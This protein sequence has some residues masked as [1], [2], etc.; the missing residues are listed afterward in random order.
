MKSVVR[1][2][3]NAPALLSR[4]KSLES[5]FSH[6]LKELAMAGNFFVFVARA[7]FFFSEARSAEGT[8]QQGKGG[9]TLG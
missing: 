9:E 7:F 3:Q 5:S 4:V 6:N 2:A 1:A 8:D